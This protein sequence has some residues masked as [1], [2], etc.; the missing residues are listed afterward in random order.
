[1]I[2][3]GHDLI[4]IHMRA[5]GLMFEIGDPELV[6]REAGLIDVKRKIFAT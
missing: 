4:P 3:I 1:M 2:E 5:Q 6:D